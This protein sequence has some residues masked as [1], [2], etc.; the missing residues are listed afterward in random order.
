MRAGVRI[1]VEALSKGDCMPISEERRKIMT[2]MPNQ[3]KLEEYTRVR[4]KIAELEDVQ[5]QI[6]Q[7]R[8]EEGLL[9]KELG[10]QRAIPKK[11]R[12][13]AVTKEQVLARI[14]EFSPSA[15]KALSARAISDSFK[16]PDQDGEGPIVTNHIKALLEKD[17]RILAVVPSNKSPK[18]PTRYYARPA[19]EEK[20][21]EV[22]KGK[23][24]K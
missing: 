9:L 7:L 2:E 17:M 24:T 15:D 10:L 4:G 18:N 19:E 23:Q 11:D 12:A 1:P 5:N 13:P 3:A 16:A 20:P 21:A 8:E 14:Q 6:D 22:R